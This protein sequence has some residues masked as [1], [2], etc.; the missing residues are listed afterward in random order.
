MEE[1]GS[2]TAPL[3]SQTSPAAI[4][5]SIVT[6]PFGEIKIN[7]FEDFCAA[8]VEPLRNSAKIENRIGREGILNL[9]GKNS[10]MKSELVQ[11]YDN[12]IKRAISLRVLIPGSKSNSFAIVKS[13]VGLI[14]RNF[15]DEIAE[16]EPV[17]ATRFKA[18]MTV[19][20]FLLQTD[21]QVDNG[22]SFSIKDIRRKVSAPRRVLV[23]SVNLEDF[24]TA[25]ILSPSE[26]GRYILRVDL[27]D[28]VDALFL[29][30]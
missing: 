24:V 30:I 11:M 1:F 15:H 12:F 6:L 7:S 9:F 25:G 21:L 20:D 19:L 2:K 13:R 3:E 29:N 4:K 8:I 5:F 10:R 18:Y 23:D 16:I 28:Q 17:T 26:K 14:S 22:G 27:P